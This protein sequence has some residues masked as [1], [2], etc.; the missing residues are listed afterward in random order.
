MSSRVFLIGAMGAGK[1]SVGT[2]LAELLHLDFVDTDQ[3]IE[4]R[5]EQTITDIFHNCGEDYFRNHEE[6]IL[7]AISLQENLVLATGGGSI[8]SAQSREYLQNRGIVCYLKVT[9]QQQVQ[10]LNVDSVRPLLPSGK[11][12]LQYFS[13]LS[14]QRDYLYQAIADIIL[15]TDNENIDTLAQQLAM[16]IRE[17]EDNWS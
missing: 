15:D 10:R 3:A 4:Q 6:Q 17:Y 9:P 12:R 5:L 7:A 1:T 14:A 11:E 13:R 16:M 2:K 8:L